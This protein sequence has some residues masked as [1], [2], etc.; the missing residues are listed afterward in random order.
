MTSFTYYV[1]TSTHPDD[2]QTFRSAWA[3]LDAADAL[4]EYGHCVTIERESDF[5]AYSNVSVFSPESLRA[6]V[7]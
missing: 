5:G 2:V 3:A 7:V 1:Y 6:E 4:V